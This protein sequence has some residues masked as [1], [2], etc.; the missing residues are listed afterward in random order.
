[1][2]PVFHLKPSRA[3]GFFVLFSVGSFALISALFAFCMVLPWTG[4]RIAEN[5][6][7]AV[8]LLFIVLTGLSLWFTRFLWLLGRKTNAGIRFYEEHLE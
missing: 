8:S 1:M 5:D 3:Y 7:A 2:T 4:D 6:R